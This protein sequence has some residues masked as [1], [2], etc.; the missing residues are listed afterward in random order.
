MDQLLKKPDVKSYM[1]M[2]EQLQIAL[3]NDEKAVQ[4]VDEDSESDD[5]CS[6]LEASDQD[7]S[8]GSD[9]PSP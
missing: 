1:A 5:E 2:F 7:N 8:L 6:Y 9:T 4:E 3:E